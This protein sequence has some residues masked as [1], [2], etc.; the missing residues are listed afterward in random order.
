MER[1]RAALDTSFPRGTR[2]S[3][4][5]PYHGDYASPSGYRSSLSVHNQETVFDTK[6]ISRHGHDIG[7]GYRDY[8]TKERPGLREGYTEPLS[9]D[10]LKEEY[11]Y[12]SS[13]DD[14]RRNGHAFGGSYSYTR[15]FED[16]EPFVYSILGYGP[17]GG[18]SFSESYKGHSFDGSSAPLYES[19]LSLHRPSSGP[20]T[21]GLYQDDGSIFGNRHCNVPDQQTTDSYQAQYDYSGS[22]KS[23]LASLNKP[24]ALPYNLTTGPNDTNTHYQQ[25]ANS[26]RIPQVGVTN[27]A[28]DYQTHYLQASG[29]QRKHETT[30]SGM[31][32][33]SDAMGDWR[34]GGGRVPTG[35]E[36]EKG[37]WHGY[38]SSFSMA[39]D[40]YALERA[41]SSSRGS[42]YSQGNNS[43][44]W[45]KGV[46]GQ[47]QVE[48]GP[49]GN[50][51]SLFQS[52]P[53]VNGSNQ[54]SMQVQ[55]VDVAKNATERKKRQSRW[56][57]LEENE[58][59]A[60]NG[61]GKKKKKS[62]WS[63]E[64]PP[65]KEACLPDIVKG[66][67]GELLPLRAQLIFINKKLQS[68]Q[69]LDDR[70]D[71]ERSPSPEPVFDN[72]GYRV[73]TREFRA[74][75][76]LTKERQRILAILSANSP[77]FK[78]PPDFR[79]AKFSTKIY[80]PVD[81]HP[82]Y[83]FIGLIIGPRGHTQ[84]KMEKETGARIFIRGK[85]SVREGSLSHASLND[86]DSLHVLIEADSEDSMNKAAG[87]VEKLL[88]PV[89][90]GQNEHKKAQ[91]RELATLSGTLRSNELCHV[92]KEPGHMAKDCPL[93]ESTAGS[94][95]AVVRK[96]GATQNSELC[97][98]CK[99]SGHLSRDCPLNRPTSGPSL[100]KGG[101][102]GSGGTQMTDLQT[103]GTDSSLNNDIDNTI[104]YV[105][106]LPLS[107]DN[108]QLKSL[109]SPFGKVVHAKVMRHGTTGIS[110]SYGFVKFDDAADA[111]QAVALMNG[112][113]LDG[114]VLLVTVK[115]HAEA[116]S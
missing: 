112:Y 61:S 65:V 110:K 100:L 56:E 1:P 71:E 50:T 47:A 38:G 72:F 98:A 12:S 102:L 53:S 69:V 17:D 46:V 14:M 91:L 96:G 108:A 34:N 90:D 66:I 93:S 105:A 86:G 6:P 106:F 92:C 68:G 9:R 58:K 29:L 60:Q 70:P 20:L 95:P 43:G 104:L 13:Y 116:E 113:K 23:N 62:R 54:G 109:F 25:P 48:T 32:L 15:P 75:D 83:N 10:V 16:K 44:M 33:N 73:N 19:A 111:A 82:E 39:Q 87:M 88:V 4:I 37:G 21:P 63:A 64:N 67:S 8:L 18:S 49:S 85:G 81:K 55:S 28:I 41:G 3:D 77:S 36:G 78:P 101:S 80:I 74:R 97:N 5:P 27:A 40:Q 11:S 99:G 94:S 115:T 76:K 59:D 30:S 7:G 22:Y 42:V 45:D 114:K 79:H 24:D 2:S 57:P 51:A 89:E 35:T 31:Y 26:S 103:R 84:K 52:R 107:V